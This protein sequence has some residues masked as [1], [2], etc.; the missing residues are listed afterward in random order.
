[1]IREP[2]QRGDQIDSLTVLLGT[3]SASGLQREPGQALV[4]TGLVPALQRLVGVL[5]LVAMCLGSG[6]EGNY[7]SSSWYQN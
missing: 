4:T 2:G 5:P 6:A 3:F 1:M 7:C